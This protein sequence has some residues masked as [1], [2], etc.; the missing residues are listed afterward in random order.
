[1]GFAVWNVIF[2]IITIIIQ[3][4]LSTESILDNM[5]QSPQA[6][7]ELPDMRLDNEVWPPED[8]V[9]RQTNPFE[10]NTDAELSTRPDEAE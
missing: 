5:T 4:A 8:R 7:M 3:N 10:D 2:I 9:D 1:M 6:P